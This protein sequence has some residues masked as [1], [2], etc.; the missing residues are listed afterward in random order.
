MGQETN[1][2]MFCI[3]FFQVR[4][5]K[6]IQYNHSFVLLTSTTLNA[7]TLISVIAKVFQLALLSSLN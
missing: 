4:F 2:S 7:S 5:V 3:N 6:R 1:I